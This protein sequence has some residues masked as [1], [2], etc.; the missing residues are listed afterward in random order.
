MTRGDSSAYPLPM[1][2]YA[3]VSTSAQPSAAQATQLQDL[4]TNLVTYSHSGGTTSDPLPAGYVPLTSGLYSQAMADISSD[5]VGPRRFGARA[6]QVARAARAARP[7]RRPRPRRCRTERVLS[8]RG[9]AAAAGAN[10]ASGRR[11][12]GGGGGTAASRRVTSAGSTG[13][14]APGNFAGHLITVDVGDS[15]YFVPALLLLALLCL[16]AGPL[17]YVSPALRRPAR[18]TS[19]GDVD[20]GDK[21]ARPAPAVLGRRK[22][23]DGRSRLRRTKPRRLP[24]TGAQP[25]LAGDTTDRDERFAGPR[26]SGGAGRTRAG[27]AAVEGPRHV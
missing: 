3:L 2:T 24:D 20:E 8:Y 4:L 5:I 15:R 22:E 11:T 10:R 19:D 7:Q 25:A 18:S 23:I 27:P 6:A 12:P 17:L 13:A 9:A 16:I 21:T 26:V 1:V 14:S